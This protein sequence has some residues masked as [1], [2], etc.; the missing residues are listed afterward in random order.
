MIN[1]DAIAEVFDAET[2]EILDAA[3]DLDLAGGIAIIATAIKGLD[4]LTR[5]IVVNQIRLT[6]HGSQD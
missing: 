6:A 2:I 4:D 5:A 1:F 3:T